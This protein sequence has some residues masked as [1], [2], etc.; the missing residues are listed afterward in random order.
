MQRFVLHNST[1]SI[2][3]MVDVFSFRTEELIFNLEDLHI[4]VPDIPI[5]DLTPAYVSGSIF[6]EGSV[7]PS[8]SV[9]S[10]DKFY[11]R[12]NGNLVEVKF[13][14][15]IDFKNIYIK[16]KYMNDYGQNN[17]A[18]GVEYL[19][20]KNAAPFRSEVA[21]RKML[22]AHVIDLHLRREEIH[23]F[24]NFT[25]LPTL[26]SF[27]KKADEDQWRSFYVQTYQ[28]ARFPDTGLPM[29]PPSTEA[30]ERNLINFLGENFTTVF[31]DISLFVDQHRDCYYYLE[32]SK[33]KLTVVRG[34]DHKYIPY[35]EQLFK[36][37]DG[38]DEQTG[39]I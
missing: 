1:Q 20:G 24:K 8:F 38:D 21:I 19:F 31:R 3:S 15:L 33:D 35:Y 6:S 34:I 26:S 22:A 23:N 9:S 5:E 16:S 11:R 12:V 25:G 36:V 13:S 17:K 28:G 10:S 27:Y 7:E 30:F 32:L 18:L 29:I 2:K 37:E 4:L 14:E 39:P